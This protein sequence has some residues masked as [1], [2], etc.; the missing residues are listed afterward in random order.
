MRPERIGDPAAANELRERAPDLGVVVAFGQFL[1]K[2][3]RELPSL[4]YL[5]NGHASLLPRYRGAA[6]IVHC[7]L[8]GDSVTGVSA[9]RVERE[10]DTGAVALQREIAIGENESGGE[11]SCRLSAL[12]ADTIEETIRQIAE[13]RV[14]WTSQEA[15]HATAA[16]KI[17]RADRVLAWS[18]PA[19]ALVRRVRAMAPTPGAFTTLDGEDLQILD[20]RYTPGVVDAEPGIIRLSQDGGLQIATGNGWLVPRALKRP[21]K[22]ALPID[23]FLRGKSIT[24][25]ARLI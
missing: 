15:A 18:D 12:T 11:L 24:D 10:M 13:G 6:P 8:N 4:G 19:E 2:S 7:I 20:A 21:G 1:P 16:P 5:I 23:E 3:I 17:E 9:M 14:V 22:C 25:G